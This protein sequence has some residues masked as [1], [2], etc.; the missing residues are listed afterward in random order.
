[1][2]EE[3]VDLIVDGMKE[4][5]IDFLAYVPDSWLGQVCR[6]ASQD[7]AFSAVPVYNE[8]TGVAVCAGAWLGG[9]KPIMLLEDSGIHESADQLNRLTI[10][11]RIPLLV[12]AGYRG[13]LGEKTHN[14]RPH[15]TAYPVAEAMQLTCAVMRRPEEVKQMIAFGQRHAE[16]FS[17][18]VVLFVGG[19]LAW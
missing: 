2:R 5:G 7:P 12:L 15:R 8:A 4:A 16:A 3:I 14:F 18:G 9:K 1:M 6:R 17:G 19:E 13:D 11:H 10:T